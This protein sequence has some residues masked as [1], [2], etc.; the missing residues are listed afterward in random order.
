M[1]N[2]RSA[3]ARYS[4]RFLLFIGRRRGLA[5]SSQLRKAE[6][7]DHLAAAL[8]TPSNLTNVVD[9]LTDS[10]QTVL[11]TLI[12]NQGRVAL[13]YLLAQYGPLRAPHRIPGHAYQPPAEDSDPSPSPLS[14]LERL[15]AD[16]LVFHDRDSTMLFIP[17]DLLPLLRSLLPLAPADP[18][19]QARAAGM[20]STLQSVDLLC[21]DLAVLLALLQRDVITPQHQRW[22]PPTFL[23]NWD[24]YNL[25]P[26]GT[27]QPRS[28]VQT[29][30]RRFI[31]YLAEAAGFLP[32][33][34]H[35]LKPTP[36]AAIWLAAPWSEQ[37]SQIWRTWHSPNLQCWQTYRLPG[38]ESIHHLASL[39][40]IIRESVLSLASASAANLAQAILV[41]RP[42]LFGLLPAG[43]M[44]PSETL[45]EIITDLLAGPYR[46]LGLLTPVDPAQ[47]DGPLTLTEP[48]RAWLGHQPLPHLASASGKFT[49][50]AYFGTE[51]APGFVRLVTP[52]SPPDLVDLAAAIELSHSNPDG[53]PENPVVINQ[54]N[55][56]QSTTSDALTGS[57]Y[58]RVSYFIVNAASLVRAR[59]NGW[60]PA[61]LVAALQRLVDRPFTLAEQ[62]LLQGWSELA[63]QA[64]IHAPLLLEVRDPQ[65]LVQLTASRRGRALVQRTLS[66]RLVTVDPARLTQLVRRLTEQTGVPPRIVV[67]EGDRDRESAVG[68]ATRSQSGWTTAE[69]AQLWLCLQVY[70]G[71]GQVVKLP[72]RIPQRLL[73]S[74]RQELDPLDLATAEIAADQVL[75]DLQQTIEGRAPFPPWSDD[76][77]P[78]DESRAIIEAALAQGQHL[79]LLY[80]TAGT[81]RLTRRVVEPYRLEW[82]GDTPYLIGFCH[83]A[84]AERTFRLDRI[85]QLAVCD[86]DEDSGATYF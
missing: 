80:Y 37:V 55:A 66:P 62:A 31:H 59:H 12:L 32:P 43:H 42:D 13:R 57:H 4:W 15:R 64:V 23:A 19:P 46:D 9:D 68:Q 70:R 20:E 11:H 47:P 58:C 1:M 75:A 54:P 25:A 51:S 2:F 5:L 35:S 52:T 72:A 74:L 60:S 76:G 83:H 8:L 14:S 63:D 36:A 24:R 48:G 79:D 18:L 73:D 41:R 17:D 81:D 28:E 78:V 61:A 49:T 33:N 6:L 21:H 7:L 53:L 30:R 86:G 44:E 39:L 56:A 77:V 29:T 85:R 10:A 34:P 69:A 82:H 22:L 65:I 71:L 16:A 40:S 26:S 67:S 45:L 38:Y 50:E 84:Q 27:P 3:L